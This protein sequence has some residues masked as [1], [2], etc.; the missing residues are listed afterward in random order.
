MI[1]K[2]PE[3]ATK[4]FSGEIFDVYQW[5]Q[6]MYDSSFATFEMLKRAD[7]VYVLAVLDNGKVILIKQQQPNSPTHITLPAGRVDLDE[8]HLEA[9]QRELQEETGFVMKNWS[10]KSVDQLHSK[11][12]W[13]CYFYVASGEI[14][15]AAQNL[16]AGE[17]IKVIETDY[18]QIV[19]LVKAGQLYW[20]LPI[21]LQILNGKEQLSDILSLS[22]IKND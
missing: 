10:L 1:R 12:Q 9:A 6:K 13:N 21:V 3:Q 19:Y 15:R 8:S 14:K 16:D 20:C 7:T 4:V 2:I 22:D 5:Q 17:K 11:I 18:Q